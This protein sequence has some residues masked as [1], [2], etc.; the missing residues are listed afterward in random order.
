VLAQAPEEFRFDL[1]L[2]LEDYRAARRRWEQNEARREIQG[3]DNLILTSTRL[4]ERN[5]LLVSVESNDMEAGAEDIERV[6]AESGKSPP[7][8]DKTLPGRLDVSVE[9]ITRNRQSPVHPPVLVFLSPSNC[10]R[11]Q[12][13]FHAPTIK[14]KHSFNSAAH[15]SR[16]FAIDTDARELPP[17]PRP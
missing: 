11:N 2:D 6:Q 12:L 1:D 9:E 3:I 7:K 10:D 14:S 13:R 4:E 16:P 5:G 8:K 17:D 15:N